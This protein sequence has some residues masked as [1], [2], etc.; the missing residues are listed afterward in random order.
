MYRKSGRGLFFFD[1][2]TGN[3]SS[4]DKV[5]VRPDISRYV[6]L[7]SDMNFVLVV[8]PLVAYVVWSSRSKIFGVKK[9][10]VR[11]SGRVFVP[12]NV[13]IQFSECVFEVWRPSKNRIFSWKSVRSCHVFV[14][15]IVIKQCND[16]YRHRLAK[17]F[18]ISSCSQRG[19][20]IRED[21]EE[22]FPVKV[23]HMM[24]KSW[25]FIKSIRKSKDMISGVS[26]SNSTSKIT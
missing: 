14:I 7:I 5:T 26:E 4:G 24:S 10:L 25:N 19:V 17:N 1:F 8:D 21:L 13:S 16:E 9:K 20:T 11:A 3:K 23:G 2:W 18:I 6:D 15:F 12:E 22:H